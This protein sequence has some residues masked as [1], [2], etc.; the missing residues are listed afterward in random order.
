[1]DCQGEARKLDPLTHGVKM[2]ML[3]LSLLLVGV[4]G[5]Q[6][7]PEAIECYAQQAHQVCGSVPCRIRKTMSR[8]LL[9]V[10]TDVWSGCRGLRHK[11]EGI[12]VHGMGPKHCLQTTATHLYLRRL[13]VRMNI[14]VV[15]CHLGCPSCAGKRFHYQC[16]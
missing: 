11:Q 3:V 8:L 4:E 1:M 13:Q 2:N 10:S 14:C 5:V 9:L 16:Y 6:A 7:F 12:H 15:S